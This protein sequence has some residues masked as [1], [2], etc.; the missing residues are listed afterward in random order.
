MDSNREKFLENRRQLIKANDASS[1]LLDNESDIS[2]K[3]KNK[4]I[5]AYVE[6]MKSGEAYPILKNKNFSPRMIFAC[7]FE[8]YPYI[9]GVLGVDT[10]QFNGTEYLQNLLDYYELHK[11]E[12]IYSH[13]VKLQ[14]PLFALLF[15]ELDPFSP[16]NS[17]SDIIKLIAVNR[18]DN[19]IKEAEVNNTFDDIKFHPEALSSDEKNRYFVESLKLVKEKL[20]NNEI[21]LKRYSI[22]TFF[23]DYSDNIARNIVSYGKIE[24]PVS[25]GSGSVDKLNFISVPN[26]FIEECK[27]IRE[28]IKSERMSLHSDSLST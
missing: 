20:L 24:N 16:T 12:E 2:S 13:N 10:E 23:N 26:G 5:T 9:L 1:V 8:I 21:E 28:Q 11:D 14:N 27:K 3:L 22:G 7:E 17:Y 19:F 4:F 15:E 18:I 6:F 25:Y